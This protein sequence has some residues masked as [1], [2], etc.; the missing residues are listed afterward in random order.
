MR[1]NMFIHGVKNDSV[2]GFM[3]FV[4]KYEIKQ[5]Y[6]KLILD[7]LVFKEI[8]ESK[9]YKTYLDFA[10]GKV[11]PKEAKKRTKAHMKETSLTP[12]DNIISEDPDTAL[13][14]ANSIS[15]TKA[16]EQEAARLVH[17][18]HERLVTE[19]LTGRRRH[20]GVTLKDTP[21]MTKKKTP[22]QPLKLK[23]M[24]ILSDT[25]ILIANTKKAIKAS[26]RDFRSQHQT[27]G[28]SEGDGSKPEVPDESKGKTKDINEG[29]CS[30]LEVPDV[31]KAMS[32]DQE[33]INESWGES[34]D[35]DRK[36][37]DE[38]TESDDDTSINLD[39]TDREEEPQRDEFVH[40]PDD[41][42][43]TDDE[44]RD[45]DDEEYVHINEEL[46]GDVNVEMKDDEPA[47][48]DKG[49]EEM[50]DVEKIKT[51]H[52]EINQEV[53]SAQVQDEVPTTTTAAPVT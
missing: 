40:N 1:N 21:T 2:L 24:E 41:Y 42:V 5:V 15:R 52:K 7:V 43:P 33:S 25:A 53:A 18:T 44:T 50:T 49:D 38:R 22:E 3:K 26:K 31:S 4:S 29:A 16:E 36:S 37:D 28:S 19:Q 20:A 47:D 46:Y 51:K 30:K 48:K 27:G 45:V 14:L 35:D 39:K 23:E 9:A 6:G 32:L 12:D 17:E 8:M 34:E 10:T 13:E 11:I